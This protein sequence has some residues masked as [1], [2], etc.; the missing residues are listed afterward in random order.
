MLLPPFMGFLLWRAHL[1]LNGSLASL[2][3]RLGCLG[4]LWLSWPV[5]KFGRGGLHPTHHTQ[6]PIVKFELRASS[7]T[8]TSPLTLNA[9]E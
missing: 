4:T 3:T 6:L 7:F 5:P 1:L 2:P 8:P 9:L